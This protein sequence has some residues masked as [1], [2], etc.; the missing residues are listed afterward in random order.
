MMLIVRMRHV[1]MPMNHLWGGL[2]LR[3]TV[4]TMKNMLS[5]EAIIT[6]GSAG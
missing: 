4:A 6:V 1:G 3:H 2:A 5:P